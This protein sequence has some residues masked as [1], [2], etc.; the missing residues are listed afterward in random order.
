MNTW[1]EPDERMGEK[2]KQSTVSLY[3]DMIF[4]SEKVWK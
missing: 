4:F 2:Y 1:T 3:H